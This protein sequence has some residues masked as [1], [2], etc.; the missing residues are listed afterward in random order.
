MPPSP[1]WHINP[2]EVTSLFEPGMAVHTSHEA[3]AATAL[4]LPTSHRTQVSAEVAL[5]VPLYRPTGQDVQELME[6]E[7]LYFPSGQLS[8]PPDVL[9]PW[10]AGHVAASTI[11]T[12]TSMKPPQYILQVFAPKGGLSEEESIRPP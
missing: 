12:D 2:Q 4:C 1:A 5:G 6:S 9:G 7:A 3:E 11:V 10:P 8:Q